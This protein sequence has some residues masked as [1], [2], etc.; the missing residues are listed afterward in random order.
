MHMKIHLLQVNGHLYE[1]WYD[2][3]YQCW[4][5]AEKDSVGNLGESIDSGT[6]EGI[7]YAIRNGFVPLIPD[8][9]RDNE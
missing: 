1:F 9:L 3:Q 4:F 8:N 5:A 7:V 6:K 2:R